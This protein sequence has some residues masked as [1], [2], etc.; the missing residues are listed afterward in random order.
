MRRSELG[1]VACVLVLALSLATLQGIETVHSELIGTCYLESHVP[2]FVLYDPPGNGSY[3][4]LAVNASRIRLQFEGQTDNLQLT[5]EFDTRLDIFGAETP[6]DA[7]GNRV[8]VLDL[9]QTWELFH[10][11]TFGKEWNEIHLSNCS[12]L[13]EEIYSLS[14]L[15]G[16][17]VWI[18][19]L[20]NK[21]SSYSLEWNVSQGSNEQ[22]TIE[23]LP[24]DFRQVGAGYNISI[25]GTEIAI[26]V[27]ESFQDNPFAVSYTF[28]NVSD[29]LHIQ[30]FSDAPITQYP[31]KTDGLRLWFS[32]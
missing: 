29:P 30:L 28:S 7:Y 21:I 23:C 11:S 9:N 27:S 2:Y 26:T 18:D 3:A 12:T 31:F 20:T 17:G 4:H 24:S 19:N 5:G 22:A 10:Y 8:F 16:N 13:G 6:H 15:E 32:L 14:D 25:F 1:V